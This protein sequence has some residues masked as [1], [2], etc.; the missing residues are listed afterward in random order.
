[1]IDQLM[2]AAPRGTRIVVVGVCMEPDTIHPMHGI[3]K[4]LSV[5]FVLAYTAEEFAS[6]LGHIADGTIPAG[7][8]I[9]GA[10]GVDGV[11]QA[12]EDLASPDR[13]AKIIVEPWRS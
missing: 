2:A 4:E 3:S 9:T 1:V 6:T 13:H 8:L 10:V 7:S 12:F 11:A 5:Q